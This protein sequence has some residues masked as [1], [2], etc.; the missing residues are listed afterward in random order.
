MVIA[1]MKLRVVAGFLAVAAAGVGGDGHAQDMEPRAYSAAPIDTNFLVGSYV[2]STGTGSLDPSLPISNVRSSINTAF[3]G[4]QRNFDLFG[5]MASGAILIPY[6]QAEVSGQVFDANKEV[7]RRGLGDIRVRIAENLIGNPVLTPAEF[8]Q[9]EPT[10]TLGASLTMI[11]PTGDYNPQHLINISSHRWAFKPE[12][13]LSQPIGNWFMDASAG[14]W[15]FTDNA[16]FFGG[17]V[18]GEEPL[19]VFQAHGGYNF[20][21][22]LWLAVD[23]TH[24]IGGDTILDG[25]NKHDFQ[26][27]SRYGLTLSVP[28][29]DGL[30][31]KAAWSGWLTARNSSAY[32]TIAFS[33]QYRWFDP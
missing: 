26:S 17:H 3:L 6:H 12:L 24:Y 7:S 20:R 25:V 21:P 2:R 19:W 15:F 11:V 16:N 27:V 5:Q 29:G 31:A 33:L 28:L 10:T 32:D 18:R 23:A 22:G 9:R 13:G 1:V 30:S 4:Y 8:A 14:G